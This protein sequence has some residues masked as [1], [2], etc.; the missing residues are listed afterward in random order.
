MFRVIRKRVRR[1]KGG[2]NLAAD[3]DAAV[4]VNRG[5]SERQRVSV[6]SRHTIVQ[7]SRRAD[8]ESQAKEEP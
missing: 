6:R 8:P 5:A 1:Q 3:V 2:V 7:R 4:A